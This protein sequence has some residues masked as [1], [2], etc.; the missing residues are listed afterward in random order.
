MVDGY[1][2]VDV[3]V[4]FIFAFENAISLLILPRLRLLS[5]V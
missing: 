4:V 1:V 2:D 5:L 3:A